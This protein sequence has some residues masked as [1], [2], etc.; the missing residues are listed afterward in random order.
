[1]K[2]WNFTK[3]IMLSLTI[4]MLYALWSEEGLHEVSTI[5][6]WAIL[7]LVFFLVLHLIVWADRALRQI[8]I[9]RAKKYLRE[10]KRNEKISQSTK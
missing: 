8:R 1:M 6:M 2:Y 4:T 10:E 9:E 3:N 7:V 5:H